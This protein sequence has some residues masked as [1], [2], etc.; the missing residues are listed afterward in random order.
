MNLLSDV[1]A[2]SEIVVASLQGDSE[3]QDHLRGI[4]IFEG[5]KLIVI[6]NEVKSKRP[7]LIEVFGSCFMIERE[8]ATRIVVLV[9]E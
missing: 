1:V 3:E 4:G 7:L 8:I 2:G 9:E 5:G 6:R